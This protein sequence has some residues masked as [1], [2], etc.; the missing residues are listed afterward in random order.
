MALLFLAFT[1]YTL[2][3]TL[4][5]SWDTTALSTYAD[6]NKCAFFVVLRLHLPLSGSL[7]EATFAKCSPYFNGENYAGCA[8]A[9]SDQLYLR[10]HRSRILWVLNHLES[11]VAQCSPFVTKSH[12]KVNFRAILLQMFIFCCTFARFLVNYRKGIVFNFIQWII[13]QDNTN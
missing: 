2:H 5:D 3:L 13:Q 7:L 11:T 10:G 8:L 12:S 1:L 9:L 4:C 6:N